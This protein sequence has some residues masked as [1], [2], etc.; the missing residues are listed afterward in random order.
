MK[1]QL[2]LHEREAKADVVVG[3]KI[4]YKGQSARPYKGVLISKSDIKSGMA[5]EKLNGLSKAI[6]LRIK[7][8]ISS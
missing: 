6:L 8:D 1:Y 7:Y 2:G 4:K 3:V 5:E